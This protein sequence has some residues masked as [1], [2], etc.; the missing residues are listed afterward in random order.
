MNVH[1][2]RRWI[3]TGRKTPDGKYGALA[4]TVD[5]FQTP[6]PEQPSGDRLHEVEA[7]AD[8]LGEMTA[9]VAAHVGVARTL[10]KNL[11]W[12]EQATTGVAAMA[13]ASL[14]R[15]YLEILYNPKQSSGW[16]ELRDA[17]IGADRPPK[18]QD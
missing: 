2:A 4:R 3:S 15:Q 16:D 14:A 6:T 12:A 1:T 18:W 9:E 11:D 13:C 5:D 17:L 8:T 10:A 7:I